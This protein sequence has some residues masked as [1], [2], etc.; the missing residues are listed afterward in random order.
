MI[1]RDDPGYDNVIIY[2][3]VDEDN[4]GHGCIF[5]K[6]IQYSEGNGEVQQIYQ[7]GDKIFL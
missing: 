1:N 7:S 3:S 6:E 5:L 2:I 4:E